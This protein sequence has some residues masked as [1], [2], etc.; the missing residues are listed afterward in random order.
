[1]LNLF[2]KKGHLWLSRPRWL[3]WGMGLKHIPAIPF[4]LSE[5]IDSAPLLLRR[6]KQIREAKYGLSN[7]YK[8]GEQKKTGYEFMFGEEIPEFQSLDG[9][10]RQSRR[11][12][13]WTQD[14]IIKPCDPVEQISSSAFRYFNGGQ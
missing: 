1:M 6:R 3:F 5:I 2:R 14:E 13:Q 7:E 11:G 9:A 8:I 12:N 4:D 10:D